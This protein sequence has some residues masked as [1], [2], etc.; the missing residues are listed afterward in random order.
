MRI[1][2]E[3]EHM[4]KNDPM[5]EYFNWLLVSMITSKYQKNHSNIGEQKRTNK[6]IC[7]K[8]K[9]TVKTLI[10]IIFVNKKYAHV[11]ILYLYY[12]GTY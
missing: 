12:Q 2:S 8:N 4:A 3:P 5:K 7:L 11:N 9:L 6:Y 10:Q 1:A